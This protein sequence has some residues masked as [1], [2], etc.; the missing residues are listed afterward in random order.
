MSPK[1]APK[2]KTTA[3]ILKMPVVPK[4]D[5]EQAK[6]FLEDEKNRK[7][8]Q[9][10]LA[11][12]LS[13]HCV[14]DEYMGWSMPKKKEFFEKFTASS[15]LKK[16]GKKSL[17]TDHSLE[18]TTTKEKDEEYMSKEQMLNTFGPNK[19]GIMISDFEQ[20]PE[21]HRPCRYTGKDDEWTREYRIF[22]DKTTQLEVDK[23]TLSLEADETIDDE[24]RLKE[25]MNT[26]D[27][28]A[29]CMTVKDALKAIKKEQS[30][31]DEDAANNGLDLKDLAE[32]KCQR[33]IDALSKDPRKVLRNIGECI[34]DLKQWHT[35]AEKSKY[36][37]QLAVDIKSSLQ[38]LSATYKKVE[39]MNLLSVDSP[40][41]LEPHLILAMAEVVDEAMEDYNKASEWSHKILGTQKPSSKRQKT[42]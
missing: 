6:K 26:F 5:L 16:V 39:A 9:N 40:E 31:G 23:N 35:G 1:A 12:Y 19:T 3:N 32:H 34:L 20:K 17:K 41:S 29:S 21:C 8:A 37:A 30:T 25:I 10:D 24:E 4:E 36:G 33:T 14:K 42:D 2:K 13:Q 38:K 7:R 22:N 11:Y 15:Y 27:S 18:S 28:A